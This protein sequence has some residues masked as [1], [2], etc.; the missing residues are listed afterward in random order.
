MPPIV[1]NLRQ[2]Q[3]ASA[4]SVTGLVR[5]IRDMYDAV[6][7]TENVA[8]PLIQFGR[9]YVDQINA[10]FRIVIVPRKGPVSGPRSMGGGMINQI[11]VLVDV[12]IWGPEPELTLPV[13]DEVEME[14][15]R[16]DAVDPM[17]VRFLN[18]INRV[19]VGRIEVA[20]AD[21]EAGE[22][23]PASINE[24]G[25]TWLL[26]FRYAWDIPRDGVV[27]SVVPPQGDDGRPTPNL[28]PGPTYAVPGADLEHVDINAEATG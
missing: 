15:N 10:P 4:T 24:H 17:L 28:S 20:D 22:S 23:D 12:H 21:A 18:V 8:A 27:F 19:S 11:A 7:E 26:T 2:L 5:A 3:G 1:R 16:Y 13:D 25:E 9:R 6:A 14:L